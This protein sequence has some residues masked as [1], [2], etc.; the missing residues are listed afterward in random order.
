MIQLPK[1]MTENQFVDRLIE[2]DANYQ[3]SL[4]CSLS[5]DGIDTFNS[6]SYVSGLLEA[7]GVDISG[8][9]VPD[10]PGFDK[11]IPAERFERK[12]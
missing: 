1:G 10:A 3:D 6:N 11:P 7:A 9:D 4:R 8:L 2:L 5:P 12:E